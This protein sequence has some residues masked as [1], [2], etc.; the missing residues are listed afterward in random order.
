MIIKKKQWD[1]L[2]EEWRASRYFPEKSFLEFLEDKKIR[3][4]DCDQVKRRI[5]VISGYRKI[6]VEKAGVQFLDLLKDII[7]GKNLQ[8]FGTCSFCGLKDSLIREEDEDSWWSRCVVC[9]K[10]CGHS[11]KPGFG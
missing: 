10:T 5:Y 1:K 9:H 4:V 8:G 7:E 3:V 6:P 2:Q 11:I